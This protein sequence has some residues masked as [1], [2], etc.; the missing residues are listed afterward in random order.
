[1][2][3]TINLSEHDTALLEAQARAANMPAE[4]YLATIVA[5][6]LERCQRRAADDL[7]AH[8]GVM[9]S[10]VSADTIPEQMEAALEEALTH[11]RL[12]R[13]WQAL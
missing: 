1:V 5:R 4:R 13:P 7:A 11:V 3:V 10:Q 8:L 9:A 6:A 2:D 12:Q